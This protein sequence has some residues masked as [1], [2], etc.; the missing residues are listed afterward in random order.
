GG[1]LALIGREEEHPILLEGS[2]NR[3]SECV[4]Q[5]V[6]RP[7]RGSLDDLRLFVEIIIRHIERRPVIFVDRA[8]EAVGSTLSDQIHLRA[9]GTARRRVIIAGGHAKLLQR[10]ECSS[11][12]T[13]EGVAL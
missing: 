9:R 10:I 12:G 3:S 5:N 4:P 1:T 11:H 6:L 8:M 7:V 2:A 13:L